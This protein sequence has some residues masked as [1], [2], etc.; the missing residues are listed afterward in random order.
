VRFVIAAV[1]S[2]I[3]ARV[4]AAADP[5]ASDPAF[6]AAL[7][8]LAACA[9][10]LDREL[11]VGYERI[12]ARCPELPQR[13]AGAGVDR[14][15]PA[16][17]R[18]PHND[19]SA[20][21]LE[22]LRTS[23]ARER[24]VLPSSRAPTVRR[25]KATLVDLGDTAHER[26]GLWRRFV[27]WLRAF[28]SA[29][30]RPQDPGLLSRILSR[31][32]LPETLMQITTYV[33][34]GVM[35]ALALLILGN[36]LR[37]A[38]VLGKKRPRRASARAAIP[39]GSGELQWQ[40]LERAAL[41]DRPR[42]L[43]TL[44]LERLAR[45]QGLPPARSLTTRELTRTVRLPAGADEQRLAELAVVAERVRYA[46]E[47]VSTADLGQA[48]EGGR[49]LLGTLGVVPQLGAQAQ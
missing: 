8:A 18:D 1:A 15:L 10:R 4:C 41:S 38:G 20:G 7:Q 17:W 27:N 48:L 43:L 19:L 3:C 13:L 28:L 35:I 47:P 6:G 23:L 25:L 22:E 46:A 39:D 33:A 40:D 16:S 32:G 36:E 44:I 26:A 45:L 30:D 29:R 42:L 11:D 14:W 9:A 31:I 24:A 2:L 49:V 37:A 12:V 5:S 34:I 21:G